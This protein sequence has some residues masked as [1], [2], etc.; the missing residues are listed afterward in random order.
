MKQVQV[1][2]PRGEL[3]ARLPGGNL[4]TSN[5]AFSGPERNVLY[6]TGGLGKE[7]GPGGLFRIVLKGTKG[8]DI[9][10]AKN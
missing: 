9:L 8:L 2:N 5:V 1:L 4:T 7:A 10:P 3:I 6:I